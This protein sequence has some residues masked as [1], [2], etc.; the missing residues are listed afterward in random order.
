LLAV[1]EAIVSHRD[2]SALFHELAS[3]L[4]QVV[5]FDYLALFLHYATSPSDA[6][7]DP[8]W[9]VGTSGRGLNVPSQIVSEHRLATC[10]GLPHSTCAT[11]SHG[12]RTRKIPKLGE[13]TRANPLPN[14]SKWQ[15]DVAANLSRLP[16]SGSVS[17]QVAD[18]VSAKTDA[19]R[20]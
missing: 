10:T 3:R 8:L 15:R 19:K 11:F 20:S 5:R 1:S 18:R 14:S 4:H 9:P 6:A 7:L 17:M 16:N 13:Y 12:L 2:L